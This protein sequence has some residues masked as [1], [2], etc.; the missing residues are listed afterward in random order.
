M[1]DVSSS[2]SSAPSGA[3]GLAK[4]RAGGLSPA[5]TGDRPCGPDGPEPDAPENRHTCPPCFA[6]VIA[7][8]QAS[9]GPFDAATRAALLREV[10]A[11]ERALIDTGP[12]DAPLFEWTRQCARAFAHTTDPVARDR[13]ACVIRALYAQCLDALRTADD[14]AYRRRRE[15]EL[16][17]AR[18]REITGG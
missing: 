14:A 17:N 10:P 4:A 15:G 9:L 11:T 13:Y 8:W 18:R 6:W 12:P 5:A 7:A 2:L 16:L 1:R 3:S